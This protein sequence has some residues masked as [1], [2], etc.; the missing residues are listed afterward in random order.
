MVDVLARVAGEGG[1]SF[2]GGEDLARVFV[3]LA[4][5]G[6]A[7]DDGKVHSTDFAA[8]L[9]HRGRH[10]V[11]ICGRGGNGTLSV[12]GDQGKHLVRGGGQVSRRLSVCL[13][14]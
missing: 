11:L 6:E 3:P 5:S 10:I 14:E 7:V 9:L 13:Q 2:D 12:G 1:E 8:P 4:G